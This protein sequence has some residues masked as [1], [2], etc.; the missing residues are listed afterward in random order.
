LVVRDNGIGFPKELDFRKAKSLGLQI[1]TDL[2]AQ[3]PGQIK[4][5]RRGGTTFRII[6]P[7]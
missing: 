6:F 1:V 3:L 4:L 5:D 7:A 2:V